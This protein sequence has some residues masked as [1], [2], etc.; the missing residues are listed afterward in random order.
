[1]HEVKL[2]NAKL[3]VSQDFAR[4]LMKRRTLL[5]VALPG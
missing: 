3:K 1:M 5:Q 4:V 2:S